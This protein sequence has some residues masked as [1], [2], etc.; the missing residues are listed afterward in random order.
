MISK[1]DLDKID[2]LVTDRMNTILGI[3]QHKKKAINIHYLIESL[4][5][6]DDLIVDYAERLNGVTQQMTRDQ[7]KIL[8]LEKFID[9]NELA[10]K[11]QEFLDALNAE[12]DQVDEKVKP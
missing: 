12:L 3:G 8:L 2:K 1:A 5:G 4:R 6:K 10:E 7:A 9:E 11:Y